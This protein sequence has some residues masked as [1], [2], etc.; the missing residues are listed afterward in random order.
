[1]IEFLLYFVCSF[2]I[3][4]AL[5]VVL[6]KNV[7]N[8]VFSFLTCLLGVATIFA[9]NGA[10]F[11]ALTQLMFY[12]SAVVVLFLF[13]IF[14]LKQK[15]EKFNSVSFLYFSIGLVAGAGIIGGIIKS[16]K[17]FNFSESTQKVSGTTL[18]I[19]KAF[20][21]S[22]EKEVILPCFAFSAVILLM[23]IIVVVF[24]VHNDEEVV[25]SKEEDK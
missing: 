19:A 8:S 3:L 18:D 17:I 16:L 7:V 12:A 20:F 4:S 2:I 5:G 15:K 10:Y 23:T 14:F 1:M 11:L 24:L 25:C 13:V 22:S 21:L 9:M 6:A